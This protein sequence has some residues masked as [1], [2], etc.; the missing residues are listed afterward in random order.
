[1]SVL[2]RS[3]ARGAVCGVTLISALAACGG[4][5]STDGSTSGADRSPYI[6]RADRICTQAHSQQVAARKQVDRIA[7]SNPEGATDPTVLLSVL[8]HQY[9][10]VFATQDQQLRGLGSAPGAPAVITQF[11]TRSDEV[12]ALLRQA[13]SAAGSGNLPDSQGVE[14][15]AKATAAQALQAAR[16]YGLKVCGQFGLR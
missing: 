16:L 4:Q 9:A 7:R 12:V 15:N 13:A 6:A 5:G 8:Y 3:C 11:L 10:R 2:L 1:M 14:R